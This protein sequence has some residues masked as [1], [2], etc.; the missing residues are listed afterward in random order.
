LL[1][2]AADGDLRRLVGK[3]VLALE[4]LGD[5]ALELGDAVDGGVFCLAALDRLDRRLLDIVG[6]V[7]VGLAGA[8][9]DDVEARRLQLARLAGNG[10]GRRGLDPFE[11]AGDQSHVDLLEDLKSLAAEADAP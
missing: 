9:A 2:A 10:H 3:A 4:L 6:R 1:A 7:E 11:R 8:K 5:G